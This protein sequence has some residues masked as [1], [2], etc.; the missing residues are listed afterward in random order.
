MSEIFKIYG[1][2]E[3]LHA[4]EKM[5]KEGGF[6]KRKDDPTHSIVLPGMKP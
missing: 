5:F 6:D 2:D 4:F 3:N 1:S